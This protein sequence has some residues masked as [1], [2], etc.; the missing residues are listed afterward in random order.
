MNLTDGHV[1]ELIQA[2]GDPSE[3]LVTLHDGP[4]AGSLALREIWRIPTDMIERPRLFAMKL[5]SN[6][7]LKDMPGGQRVLVD[8]DDFDADDE[9]LF[10]IGVMPRGLL[11]PAYVRT[12][13]RGDQ[14]Q[15]TRSVT[16]PPTLTAKSDLRILGRIVMQFRSFSEVEVQAIADAISAPA[17]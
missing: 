11:V 9:G 17:I 16:K 7:L 6:T 2:H 3:C 1:P 10:I 4:D 14:L 13:P 12:M 15:V 8:P 5:P